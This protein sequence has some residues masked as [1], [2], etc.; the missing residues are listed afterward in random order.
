[1]WESSIPETWFKLAEPSLVLH[2]RVQRQKSRNT[3]QFL[4]ET[5]KYIY[6]IRKPMLPRKMMKNVQKRS[7]LSAVNFSTKPLATASSFRN[8]GVTENTLISGS[9]QEL[10]PRCSSIYRFKHLFNTSGKFK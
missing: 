3:L 10:I 9:K 7:T 8:F 2:M 5:Q 4:E 6:N 1:M